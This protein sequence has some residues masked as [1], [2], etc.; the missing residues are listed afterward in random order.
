[1]ALVS[2]LAS[3]L[4]GPSDVRAQGS[5][6]PAVPARE[7]AI[8]TA[9]ISPSRWQPA[10]AHAGQKKRLLQWWGQW[11][12]LLLVSLI[13][14]AQNTHTDLK[15]AVDAIARVHDIL[16]PERPNQR[17]DVASWETSIADAAHG[18]ALPLPGGLAAD[19]DWH[20]ARVAIAAETAEQ[21]VA[22]IQCRQRQGECTARLRALAILTGLSI[23]EVG[24]RL[25]ARGTET[26]S[27]PGMTIQRLRARWLEQRPDLAAALLEVE[28]S[29]IEIARAE[30][31]RYPRLHLLGELG[32]SSA[33]NPPA[34]DAGPTDG[35][36]LI[37]PAMSVPP[38]DAQ[39]LQT[40]LEARQADYIAAA[41]ELRS[42]ARE[43]AREA[44][45]ALRALQNAQSRSK[46]RSPD[47]W[48]EQAMAWIHLYRTVGGGWGSVPAQSAQR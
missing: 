44:E 9:S 39:R 26:V 10:L 6:N 8:T 7:Q 30:A 23:G 32:T 12:D 22:W 5:S 47:A 27:V 36:E 2:L 35:Q 17:A 45:D 43:A 16:P 34:Q 29:R 40:V 19:A 15:S 3:L 41:S 25:L 48:L 38:F 37:G 46:D 11:N 13:E 18:G 14:A 1:M 28:R 31:Q 24:Q 33:G 4:A 21:Y 42:R 20:P